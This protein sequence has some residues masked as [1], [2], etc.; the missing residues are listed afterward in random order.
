L[1]ITPLYRSIMKE[2]KRESIAA[3]KFVEE[4]LNAARWLIKAIQQRRETIVRVAN[5][6]VQQQIPF[7]EK[8][9]LYL[10]PMVMQGAAD[11]LKLHVATIS[12]VVDGKYMQ[13]P[14][15]IF[16]FKYFFSIRIA[17]DDTTT[18]LSSKSVKE[19]VRELVE[20]EEG[21][22]LSDQEIVERLR[23]EGIQLARRTVAK[24]RGQLNILPARYRK[25]I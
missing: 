9:V 12:R 8:G 18:Q 20:G 21:Q 24:Y 1:R 17:T 4:K 16:E 19:R 10:K 13:T 25:K 7:F 2:K 3:R 5:Y 14:R 11:A 15:G 22:Q 23:Q 6:I